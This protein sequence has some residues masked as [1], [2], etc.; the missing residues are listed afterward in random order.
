ML[1]QIMLDGAEI[2]LSRLSKMGDWLEKINSS[3]DWEIF[4]A[5]IYG[6]IRKA[7][8]SLGGRPPLDEILMFKTIL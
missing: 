2:Q 4:R 5:P 6:R 3:I 8:Y 7:D 1:R